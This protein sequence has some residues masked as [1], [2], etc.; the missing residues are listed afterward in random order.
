MRNAR[1]HSRVHELTSKIPV[2]P[3]PATPPAIFRCTSSHSLEEK[4]EEEE[5]G[6]EKEKEEEY[7][8]KET[9]SATIS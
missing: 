7:R 3:T 4:E 2:A 9:A 1:S 5:E 6:E 8:A